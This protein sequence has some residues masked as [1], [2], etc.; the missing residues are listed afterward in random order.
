MHRIMILCPETEPVLSALKRI[1]GASVESVQPVG[2]RRMKIDR[3]LAQRIYDDYA[4]GLDGPTVANRN[5]VS[6]QTVSRVA[7]NPAHYGLKGKP[8]R[9][10]HI[11]RSE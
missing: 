8:L 10:M 7:L 6:K 2:Y 5:G 1:R 4:G 9:R 11:G 3:D